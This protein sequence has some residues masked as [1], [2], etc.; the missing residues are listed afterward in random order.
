M[1]DDRI[2]IE[3]HLVSENLNEVAT[4]GQG[5]V[6]AFHYTTGKKMPLPEALKQQIR[7]IEASVR[8]A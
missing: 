2:T 8:Q 7:S 5:L 4:I 1:K 6:V 3:H